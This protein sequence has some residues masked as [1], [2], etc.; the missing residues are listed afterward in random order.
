VGATATLCVVGMGVRQF[1]SLNDNKSIVD[2]VSMVHGKISTIL[3]AATGKS[4]DSSVE[5]L[6]ASIKEKG[7]KFPTSMSM[8]AKLKIGGDGKWPR[9]LWVFGAKEGKAA[10]LKAKLDTLFEDSLK[11]APPKMVPEIKKAVSIK[12][13]GDSAV[14]SVTPP[15]Q[16]FNNEDEKLKAALKAH[17]PEFSADFAVA[18]TIEDILEH[19]SDN[20]GV[21]VHGIEAKVGAVFAESMIEALSNMPGLSP[22][23]KAML[24]LVRS[25]KLRN[26]IYYDDDI[27]A[28]GVPLPPIKDVLPGA[29][30]ELG[31]MAKHLKGLQ[32]ELA[33]VQ[34]L[35]VEGL[36]YQ[37]E[38]TV[39]MKGV[40]P[41]PLAAFCAE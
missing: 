30:Q 18:R 29:C 13:D 21:A 10:D 15:K 17:K 34:Q 32:D 35:V 25:S 36:P 9:M 37:W 41:G 40:N 14:V 39:D 22:P 11:S 3:A 19:D 23:A 8:K 1:E 26:E 33:E 7:N 16:E 4:Y 12:E 27:L 5:L 6:I 28:N 31:P 20:V 24:G 38:L 2:H